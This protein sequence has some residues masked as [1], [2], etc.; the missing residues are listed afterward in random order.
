M[1][2]SHGDTGHLFII[3]GDLTQLACDAILIPSSPKLGLKDWQDLN[4][5]ASKLSWA[6]ES[7]TVMLAR[8]AQ[9]D[10]GQ[11]PAVWIGNVG[12]PGDSAYFADFEAVVTDYATQAA[13]EAQAGDAGRRPWRKTRLALPFIGTRHGGGKQNTGEIVER[14]VA[15]LEELAETRNV[16]II[17]VARS[18][19]IYAAAQRAPASIAS[20]APLVSFRGGSTLPPTLSCRPARRNWLMQLSP[21]S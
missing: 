1:N 6:S 10:D 15:R 7:Q 3:E 4:I 14:L 13:V 20:R 16:D 2:Y 9:S 8:A 12:L 17:L 5:D 19:K 18:R 11:H 21:R